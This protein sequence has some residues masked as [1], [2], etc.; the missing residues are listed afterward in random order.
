MPK[1][2][3]NWRHIFTGLD[4]DDDDD[5]YLNTRFL[6]SSGLVGWSVGAELL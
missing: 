4:D 6:V 5:R 1:N 2:P 3:I